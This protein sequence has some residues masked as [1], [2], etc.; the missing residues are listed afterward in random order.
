MVVHLAR[1]RQGA[2]GA[3]LVALDWWDAGGTSKFRGFDAIERF[4]YMDLYFGCDGLLTG[5]R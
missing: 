3:A 5:A 4:D 1:V 2:I